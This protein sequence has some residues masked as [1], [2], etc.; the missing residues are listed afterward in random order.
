MDERPLMSSNKDTRIDDEAFSDADVAD[1]A[2]TAAQSVTVAV[3]MQPVEHSQQPVFS[4]FTTVQAGSG[5]VFID[6]GFFEPQTLAYLSRLGQP[7]VKVPE[8]IDGTLACRMALSIETVANLANQ[9]N[10]LLRNAAAA[11]ART[12]TV[13]GQSAER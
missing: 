7:G 10:Q 2:P 6:F 1:A 8:A 13:P 9:L 3:R 12:A 5:V 4:N 11:Q